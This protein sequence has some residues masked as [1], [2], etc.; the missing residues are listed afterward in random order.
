M[1]YVIVVFAYHTHLLFL[2]FGQALH[3]ATGLE[4]L[5]QLFNAENYPIGIKPVH[6]IDGKIAKYVFVLPNLSKNG[7]VFMSLIILT[8]NGSY[9]FRTII[10]LR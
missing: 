1:Q 7:Y 6:G 10:V 9:N 2:F 5:V 4:N 8:Q 3:Q